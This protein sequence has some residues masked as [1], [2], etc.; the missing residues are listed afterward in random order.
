MILQCRIFVISWGVLRTSLLLVW[1]H[2]RA[3]V[4][5]EIL[6]L[7][8]FP[9]IEIFFF[10]KI[11]LNVIKRFI[12]W[13]AQ[14]HNHFFEKKTIIILEL[15]LSTITHEKYNGFWISKSNQNL[16]VIILKGNACLINIVFYTH[17][18]FILNKVNKVVVN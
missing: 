18:T 5:K 16:I 12:H 10:I 11:N 2:W 9:C 4:R 6:T 17:L 1:E 7:N 13:V 3:F 8:I 15:S 14:L